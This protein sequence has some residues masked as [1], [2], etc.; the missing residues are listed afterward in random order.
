MA[1]LS[2]FEFVDFL[3]R[4]GLVADEDLNRSLDDLRR[5]SSSDLPG[6]ADVVANHLIDAG[7]ITRWHA[8]KIF[9]KKYKG[10]R[11]GR[12]KL[13]SH[14][15]SGQMSSVYLAEHVLVRQKRA[16]KVLPK[17]RT[18]SDSHRKLFHLEAQAAASLSHPNIVPTYDVDNDGEQHFLVMEYVDGKTLQSIVDENGPLP[19]DVA[20]N[21]IAQAAEG[22]GYAHQHGVV[23]C[24]V[25]PTNIMVDQQ[26]MVRVL[27]L[28]L[29]LHANAWRDSLSAAHREEILR[30][31]NYLS[32]EQLM[33]SHKVDLRTDIY[34][35]GCTFYFL[36][37]GHPPFT[38][39]SLFQKAALHMLTMPVNV[40][41]GRPD[42]PEELS[43]I[44]RKML[45]KNPDLRYQ[46]MR[47]VVEALDGWLLNHGFTFDPGAG[48][49]AIRE[50]I[51]KK[52]QEKALPNR[53]KPAVSAPPPQFPAFPPPGPG[54]GRIGGMSDDRNMYDS[55]AGMKAGIL[56]LAAG[57]GGIL[58]LA[59]QMEAGNLWLGIMFA[60]LS[61][62][63][64]LLGGWAIYRSYNGP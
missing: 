45:Q 2:T 17:S 24:D 19:F 25:K 37:T 27:D 21:F 30:T 22:L 38:A 63:A 28:G 52:S 53:S 29:A 50:T 64:I 56:M 8:D 54:A 3:S 49:A 36:L 15:G 61:P 55:I 16:I 10:F 32:P 13:L 48:D 47:E 59:A 26:G 11:L 35:L 20:C 5:K 12:Y 42:C 9:D 6:N 40:A 41:D 14:L 62:V 23:H 46:T 34:N 33:D 57:L 7:L 44:C 58:G 51:L 1:K 31:A 60:V 4:S 43:A 18:Y 39:A